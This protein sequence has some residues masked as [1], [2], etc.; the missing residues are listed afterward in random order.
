MEYIC[1]FNRR[2]PRKLPQE[3]QRGSRGIAP[4]VP[5]LVARWGR[6]VNTTPRPLY[7]WEGV[8]VPIAEEAGWAPGPVW[9]GVKNIKSCIKHLT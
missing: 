3:T 1:V 2:S 6:V 4:L 8:P 5:N 9:T 7:L